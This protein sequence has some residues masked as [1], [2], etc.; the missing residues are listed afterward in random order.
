MRYLSGFESILCYDDGVDVAELT[1]HPERLE[2]DLDLVRETGL[3]WFRY[4]W[5]WHAVERAPGRY[6]WSHTDR[7]MEALRTRAIR[8]VVDPCHHISIPAFL[9]GGFADPSFVERYFRFVTA[10]AER[11]PWITQY[12]IFNEPFPTTLFCGKTGFWHPYRASDRDF[13]GMAVNVATAICRIS[14]FLARNP[15][16]QSVHFETCEHHQ[17]LDDAGRVWA[18]REN[19]MRFLTTDLVLGRVN[20]DHPLYPWLRDNGLTGD[21]MRWLWKHPA[22]IDVLGLNYYVHSE[23]LWRAGASGIESVRPSANPRGFR[24]VAGDYVERYGRRVLLGETNIRGTIYDRMTWLKYSLQECEALASELGESFVGYCW[25]PLWD[26][27]SWAR[28]LCRT[29][30]TEPDPVGIYMLEER[31]MRRLGS[32]LSDC[33]RRLVRGEWTSRDVPACRLSPELRPALRG[34]ERFFTGWRWVDPP[35]ELL[36]A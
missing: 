30:K 22:R 4:P 18:Q 10:G 5:R 29:A 3:D 6:D 16:F 14:E 27:C 12:T 23:I 13:V 26:S 28:D 15:G 11:Y 8:P 17:G 35:A 31:T 9:D 32:P 21:A 36:A 33:F 25:F 34:Y 1:R 19:S 20:Q 2:D 7:A 24:A